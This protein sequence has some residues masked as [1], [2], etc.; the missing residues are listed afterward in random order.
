MSCLALGTAKHG[1][2]MFKSK[3]DQKL[4]PVRTELCSQTAMVASAHNWQE[5]RETMARRL[6]R[7]CRTLQ[8]LDGELQTMTPALGTSRNTTMD[9]TNPSQTGPN[10][11]FAKV[12]VLN[13]GFGRKCKL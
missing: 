4:L 9:Q 11:P 8:T 2:G 12:L 1:Q 13:P 10:Q 3:V 6:A 5:D 7:P